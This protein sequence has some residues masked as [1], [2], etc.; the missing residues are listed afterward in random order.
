MKKQK[1][2]SMIKT[3]FAGFQALLFLDSHPPFHHWPQITPRS[4]VGSKNTT[5]PFCE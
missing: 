1:E 5:E 3:I 4:H 2:L